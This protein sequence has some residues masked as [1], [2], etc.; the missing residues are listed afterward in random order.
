VLKI[1]SDATSPIQL[2]HISFY[3]FLVDQEQCGADLWID[4]KAAHTRIATRYIQIMSAEG[5][6]WEN[7]WGLE[8]P[9]KLRSEVTGDSISIY[10]LSALFWLIE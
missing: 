9:G 3:D 7:I 8:Y 4:E 10:L 1:P 2:F 5:G 6:L